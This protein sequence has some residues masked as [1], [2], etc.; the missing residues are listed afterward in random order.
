MLKALSK[1]SRSRQSNESA[2]DSSCMSLALTIWHG[3]KPKEVEATLAERSWSATSM[4]DNVKCART[5]KDTR[6]P[7]WKNFT[8]QRWKRK[9]YVATLEEGRYY[10]DQYKVVQPD[11]GGGSST[12][13]TKEHPEHKHIV[14]WKREFSSHRQSKNDNPNGRC[15]QVPTPM[16]TFSALL[17]LDTFDALRTPSELFVVQGRTVNTY[18]I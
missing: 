18:S 13:K 8:E 15:T 11:Q 1:R 5:N 10:R 3:R 9:N 17:F 4:T 14:Q 7:T 6:S 12:V 16:H 2:V